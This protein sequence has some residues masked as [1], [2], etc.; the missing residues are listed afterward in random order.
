MEL[1]HND[2]N[3]KKWEKSCGAVV[4]R[5]QEDGNWE[6][7]LVRHNAGH[8]SFPKGHVEEGESEADTAL[9]EIREE[10]GLLVELDASFRRTVTYSPSPGVM[11][12]VIFFLARP[13]GGEEKRQEEE[14]AELAWLPFQDALSTITFPTDRD[15]LLDAEDYHA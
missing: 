4:R 7:L 10:T 13:V 12:D 1:H 6:Y 14:I 3:G 8:W 11:K 9:R 15:V 2:G 5:K